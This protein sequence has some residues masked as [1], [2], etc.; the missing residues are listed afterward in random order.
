MSRGPGSSRSSQVV[1]GLWA[2]G[3]AAA[4]R[5]GHVFMRRSLLSRPQFA[6]LAAALGLGV[7]LAP[8][9]AFAAAEVHRFNIALSATPT[10]VNA[11]DF[12]DAI[13]FYNRTVV[14]APPRG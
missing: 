4:P 7:L 9:G 1:A 6:F 3:Y 2:G 13:D 10:S 8:A 5:P 12:N 11:G 14:T